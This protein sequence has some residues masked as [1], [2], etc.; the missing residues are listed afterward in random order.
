LG[1]ASAWCEG[2][3]GKAVQTN[4]QS[5]P[6]CLIRQFEATEVREALR[7]A[8]T[9]LVCRVVG[10]ALSAEACR[11]CCVVLLNSVAEVPQSRKLTLAPG[12]IYLSAP[13]S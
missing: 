9:V 5:W 11:S 2:C 3:W 10:D 13:V 4:P 12:F 6:G 8:R 7:G 1:L